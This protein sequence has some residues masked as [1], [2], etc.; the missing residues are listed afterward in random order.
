MLNLNDAQAALGFLIGQ[1]SHI[2][3]QVWEK[4]YP[5]ITY[6]QFVPVDSS[7]HPWATSVTYFSTDKSGAADFLHHSA[8]D[9]PMAD[10]NRNKEEKPVAM[11]GIG[12][13]YDLE[14]LNQARMLGINLPADKASAARRAYEEFVEAIAYTGNASKGFAGLAN[15]ASVTASSVADPADSGVDTTWET[16]TVEH[17]LTDINAGV[18]G[19][20][21]ASK[22]VE[23]ADTV[24]LPLTSLALLNNKRLDATMSMS[25]LEYIK[26]AN[27]YTM[28]TGQPLKIGAVRQLETAGSGGTKRMVT[29]RRDPEVV[30][31]HIPMPLQFLAPQQLLMTF[32]VPGMFRLAGVDVRRPG[33]MRYS[34]GI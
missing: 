24:L 5:D 2:E 4:K 3:S 6:S 10:I 23:L 8:N 1:T 15:N 17:I 22:T 29:Y 13:Q 19:V 18:T 20:W 25:V 31:L 21:T 7:A 32:R 33:A 14:E 11:G 12:Y 34:D 30:K 27:I 28:Q 26:K 9:F 16:K